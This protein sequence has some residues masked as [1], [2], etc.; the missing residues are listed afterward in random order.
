MGVLRG[1]ALFL[2]GDFTGAQKAY[3]GAATQRPD[4]LPPW[5]G[6]AEV[7]KEL[8]DGTGVVRASLRLVALALGD[9]DVEASPGKLAAFALRLHRASAAD[10]ADST[11]LLRRALSQAA[12]L[13]GDNADECLLALAERVKDG[14]EL[15]GLLGLDE[16]PAL[17]RVAR[18]SSCMRGHFQQQKE[19]LV[20]LRCDKFLATRRTDGPTESALRV[21]V[22]LEEAFQWAVLGGHCG[23]AT[24]AAGQRLMLDNAS[25]R[26]GQGPL[27]QESDADSRY[28]SLCRR[29][30][31]GFP[32]EGCAMSALSQISYRRQRPSRARNMDGPTSCRV[33]AQRAL[34]MDRK[35]IVGWW[36]LGCANEWSDPQKGLQCVAQSRK[37][38]RAAGTAGWNFDALDRNLRLHEARLLDSVGRV[39]EALLAFDYVSANGEPLERAHAQRGKSLSLHCLGR[40]E[41]FLETLHEAEKLAKSDARLH[42][43][44]SVDLAYHSHMKDGVEA[45]VAALIALEDN[46]RAEGASKSLLSYSSYLRGRLFWKR[47]GQYRT[48]PQFMRA[49]IMESASSGDVL[50]H[51]AQCF[52]WLGHFYARIKSDWKRALKCYKKS[53][54]LDASCEGAGKALCRLLQRNEG[55]D[56]L[57]GICKAALQRTQKALWAL[58]PLAYQ[59]LRK[60]EA[61]ESLIFLQKL[62]QA[63]PEEAMAWEALAMAYKLLG[64]PTSALRSFKRATELDPTRLSA[65]AEA[66]FILLETG[67]TEEALTLLHSSE[68]N[69]NHVMLK[70]ILATALKTQAECCF[71]DVRLK[72]ASELLH[73]ASDTLQHLS[74][75]VTG[76]GV[77]SEV[78]NKLL[79]DVEVLH[80]RISPREAAGGTRGGQCTQHLCNARR[81]Y[82]KVLHSSPFRASSWGDVALT[83]HLANGSP[84][85]TSP[86]PR[87]SE[88]LLRGALRI[89]P[90]NAE[91]WA[92][93]GCTS[94]NLAAKEFC[95]SK[96]LRLQ[97]KCSE[98]WAALGQLYMDHGEIEL[99]EECFN[100]GRLQNPSFFGVWTGSARSRLQ[101]KGLDEECFRKFEHAHGLRGNDAASLQGFVSGSLVW[102]EELK[103]DLLLSALK[104]W[105]LNRSAASHNSLGLVQE[106]L[107]LLNEAQKSFTSIDT[108]SKSDPPP[109]V[110]FSS[111]DGNY[112]PNE[113]ALSNLAA[114]KCKLGKYD[115]VLQLGGNARVQG[116][117]V[118]PA[119]L[120]AEAISLCQLGDSKGSLS[121][122]QALLELPQI[123]NEVRIMCRK[124]EMKSGNF[125][126]AVSEVLECLESGNHV[127][128]ESLWSTMLVMGSADPQVYQLLQDF[129]RK[130]MKYTRFW[131]AAAVAQIHKVWAVQTFAAGSHVSS[132]LSL[133]KSVHCCPQ[134]LESHAELL[135]AAAS[136]GTGKINLVDLPRG[137]VANSSTFAAAMASQ[138]LSEKSESSLTA[139][140][141][142]LKRFV[143]REP[144]RQELWELLQEVTY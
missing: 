44:I 41:E 144:H 97:P 140:C 143:I 32:W 124:V 82:A 110:A 119:L 4:A 45:A 90:C 17:A 54:E 77:A 47:G 12:N 115:E 128:F 43:E 127:L 30:A 59:L 31:H 16:E 107:G 105:K 7:C 50:N 141:A 100:E 9:G 62:L 48:D 69:S 1:K 136:N 135:A 21:K 98:A 28:A 125:D 112:G 18:A 79:G 57:I 111:H 46:M 118:H 103:P 87:L 27:M 22:D 8:C 81:A 25:F 122:F 94:T 73:K 117:S 76:V 130:N 113:L 88:L 104:S 109:R 53:V 78:L 116:M 80:S 89:E 20:S 2:T 35:D 75:G 120:F 33:L 93:L 101:V 19:R 29:M 139:A 26:V 102:S 11:D 13:E 65:V 5:Q 83:Y 137:E 66:A 72:G 131:D 85:A 24:L 138:A 39:K 42:A 56:A 38:C 84:G 96:S 14:E 36:V 3:E 134:R 6:L 10:D 114:L 106:A 51:H 49:A 129:M 68:G 123:P 67:A 108:K 40:E 95:L 99:A 86:S 15:G 132:L 34:K 142:V 23:V 63:K 91:T 58:F 37:L 70:A 133:K 61:E 126:N 55:E 92:A 60:G 71:S 121:K 74:P 52:K 64:R